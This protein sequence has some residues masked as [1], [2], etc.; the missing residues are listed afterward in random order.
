MPGLPGSRSQCGNFRRRRYFRAAPGI[1]PA[2]RDS[3]L[4]T[5]KALPS[6]FVSG[7]ASAALDEPPGFSRRP[8]RRD[9][10]GG[11][12]GLPVAGV[13]CYVNLF[14][15]PHAGPPRGVIEMGARRIR[16]EQRREDMAKSR[17][18]NGMRKM[19]ERDRRKQRMI[20]II[21]KQCKLP[22]TPVVMCCVGVELDT[23]SRLF[24]HVDVDKVVG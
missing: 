10:P 13:R 1:A 21:K 19:Y 18:T 17:M 11:S 22:Y 12:S 3:Q 4:P 8:P 24:M 7:A 15:G 16:R 14:R 9:K 23:P 20:E 5:K 6:N 2:D